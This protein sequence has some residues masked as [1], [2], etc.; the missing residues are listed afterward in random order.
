MAGGGIVS[1]YH[2]VSLSGGKDST[3]MLIMMLERGMPVDEVVW[4]DTGW[5]FPA[6]VGHIGKVEAETGVPVTRLRPDLPFNYWMFDHVRMKGARAGEAGYGWARMGSRWCTKIKTSAIDRHVKAMAGRRRV[7]QYVGIA[8]DEAHRAKGK[9]Y[10]LVEWGVTEAEAL[11]YCRARGYDWGGLYDRFDRVSCWCCPLQR[12]SDLRELRRSFPDLW[13]LLRDM[14][15]RAWNDFRIDCTVEQLERRFAFEDCQTT[16][17][18]YIAE[19][20]AM[21]RRAND[22]GY[23]SGA[24]IASERQGD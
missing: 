5:E 16:V 6:M 3:A 14:D 24:C 7:V 17:L 4:F 19:R 8:A 10:P 21:E 2:V 1:A 13:E 22:G 12:L 18:G 9:R 23:G 11:A 15:A 20:E